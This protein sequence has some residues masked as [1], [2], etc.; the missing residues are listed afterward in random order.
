MVIF[1]YLMIYSFFYISVI[2]FVK[3]LDITILQAAYCYFN[4]TGSHSNPYSNLSEAIQSANFMLQSNLSEAVL[5][6]YFQDANYIIYDSFFPYNANLFWNWESI[7]SRNIS[8]NILPDGCL[9]NQTCNIY[10]TLDVKTLKMSFSLSSSFSLSNMIFD[11]KD[12]LLDPIKYSSM[13]CYS[14]YI[15]CCDN[16]SFYNSSNDCYLDKTV[17]RA[18]QIQMNMF[19]GSSSYNFL[20][21]SNVVFENIYSI[22]KNHYFT[23]MVKIQNNANIFIFNSSFKGLYFL[24]STIC[25]G[26]N[27]YIS[28]SNSYFIDYNPFNYY[29]EV[30]VIYFSYIFLLTESNSIIRL[31]NITVNTQFFIYSEQNTIFIDNTSL[32]IKLNSVFSLTFKENIGFIKFPYGN[33]LIITNTNFTNSPAYQLYG[34]HLMSLFATTMNS[35]INIKD[36]YFM[37]FEFDEAIFL[38][39]LVNLT[40]II[41]NSV[42]KNIG[43]RCNDLPANCINNFMTM[44]SFNTIIMNDTFFLNLTFYYDI[45][46]IYMAF[47]NR[48]SMNNCTFQTIYYNLQL[49]QNPIF[50]YMDS[51]NVL[52]FNKLIFIDYMQGTSGELFQP[53]YN[54]SLTFNDSKF[55]ANPITMTSQIVWMKNLNNISFYSTILS[56]MPSYYPGILYLESNNYIIFYNCSCSNIQSIVGGLLTIGGANSRVDFNFS[57]F[58]SIS[59]HSDGGFIYIFGSNTLIY[60]Q[61]CI[62]MSVV[63]YGQGGL[64]YV[65]VGQNIYIR[66]TIVVFSMSLSY[67][68]FIYCISQNNVFIDNLT[69]SSS[70]SLNNGGLFSG[71]QNNVYFM[72]N[73]NI[74]LTASNSGQGGCFYG[75]LSNKFYIYNVNFVNISAENE[76]GCFSLDSSNIAIMENSYSKFINT[77]TDGG[78]FF[79]KTGNYIYVSNCVFD[80]L[81]SMFSAG[82]LKAQENNNISVIN[83]NFS[84]IYSQS[85][86]GIWYLDNGNF[87]SVNGC[88]A[89]NVKALKGGIIL[90]SDKNNIGFSLN[91]FNNIQTISQGGGL[92]LYNVN[93]ISLINNTFSNISTISGV[94]GLIYAYEGNNITFIENSLFSIKSENYGGFLFF[95]IGNRINASFNVFVDCVAV[96]G[97]NIL[98]IQSNNHVYL[99][100]NT[101]IV[102]TYI[103]MIDI[104]T[105]NIICFMNNSWKIEKAEKLAYFLMAIDNNT[106]SIIYENYVFFDSFV[107]IYQIF[108]LATYNNFTIDH[109]NLTIDRCQRIFSLYDK[110]ILFLSHFTLKGFVSNYNEIFYV[111]SANLV[112]FSMKLKG[113]LIKNI[114][115]ISNST[116]FI[117]KTV[118]FTNNK[119][120]LFFICDSSNIT[121]ISSFFKGSY[122]EKNQLLQATDSYVK[123]VKS[124]AI[125]FASDGSGSVGLFTRTNFSSLKSVFSLN[126]AYSDGGVMNFSI[127]NVISNNIPKINIINS[128]FYMNKAAFHGG[129]IYVYSLSNFLEINVKKSL[130]TLNN[131]FRGGSIYIENLNNIRLVKNE[132]NQNKVNSNKFTISAYPLL[133]AKGGALYISNDYNLTNTYDFPLKI[134]V[135]YNKFTKNKADIGGVFY[136]EGIE[137]NPE[138][139]TKNKYKGNTAM[140][141][142]E[143]WASETYL[144]RFEKFD[145]SFYQ[146]DPEHDYYVKGE[147]DNIKSGYIYTDCLLKISGYDRFNALTLNTDENLMDGLFFLQMDQLSY[148]NKLSFSQ[149]KGS[150]CLNGSFLRQELPLKMTFNYEITSK[151]LQRLPVKDQNL[152]LSIDFT[153][154]SI[155]DRLTENYECVNCAKDT[156]S[157]QADFSIISEICKS[158]ENT[159]FYC[160]G[161]GNYTVKPGYWRASLNSY[162]FYLCPNQQACLGDFRNFSDET[163]EYLSIYASSYCNI[164]YKGILCAE[165]EDNYGYLDGHICTP[166]VDKNYYLQVFGN[167]LLRAIFTIYLIKVGVNMCLSILS[168]KPDRNRIIS[169]NLL[170]IFTNHMQILG[171]IFNLP[172]SFPPELLNG[173]SYF[174]S[175]SP[176]VSEAF[177]IECILKSLGSSISL[178]YFKLIMAAIYPFCLVIIFVIFVKIMNKVNL[179]LYATSHRTLKNPSITT[180]RIMENNKITHID[181]ICAVLN[182]VSLICY[183]DIAKMTMS[184]FGCVNIEE[185]SINTK[186]LLYSDFRIECDSE[187]HKQ[188]IKQTAAPIMIFFLFFYPIYL[189]LHMFMNFYKKIDNISF[190]FRFSYFFYAYKRKFFYWDFVILLR[191]LALIFINSF[192]FSRITDNVDLYPILIVIFIFSLAFG[193]QAYCKPFATESFYM[194]NGVEEYSLVVSFYTVIIALIYMITGN[195]NKSLVTGL[196][197]LGFLLNLSFFVLWMIFYLKYHNSFRRFTRIFVSKYYLY[198]IYIFS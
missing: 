192:F 29:E 115:T 105:D 183:A 50:V 20:W 56:H 191:K 68:G 3:A 118:Y 160:Y 172:I 70:S 78:F 93:N 184:M 104:E 48:I 40:I 129:C 125:N 107:D 171:F 177:S 99:Y 150:I 51:N 178:Q 127:E 10:T 175:V 74:M 97:G 103:E 188:W 90:V 96:L 30:P 158:C 168:E 130:F 157:F 124:T 86:G 108:Y 9:F 88:F 72:N 102:N 187:Y 110:S 174:L 166:C 109:C 5:N 152:I 1:P 75:F 44:S 117:N 144:L 7:L 195:S 23:N 100:N 49:S 163:T 154:C 13:N 8:I 134:H 186:K 193:L 169:S 60:M 151:L 52:T 120:S 37:N 101:F 59:A 87:L 132:F 196:L 26:R 36:S 24:N 147:I 45:S 12:S 155:G 79:A 180:P 148:Y 112:I 185:N 128:I 198:N 156:Y 153:S 66:D 113:N 197:V 41:K 149:N 32:L 22:D 2:H 33:S 137:I 141:Y 162:T 123:F 77:N 43:K 165:C 145:R 92:W 182:L 76:G 31:S 6:I 135:N 143:I 85:D 57:S 38:N 14:S 82:F 63:S 46:F 71:I 16:A 142:G 4:C 83:S 167:I 54:N 122:Q 140:Y 28:I 53:L 106:G 81:N 25:S 116:V 131:A 121:I 119:N 65:Q 17:I 170:K 42:F 126:L 84:R 27:S 138:N 18:S 133:R 176:N 39:G 11:Y 146:F 173:F 21:M 161:G 181:L 190:N 19:E 69:I 164:G 91:S 73:S 98:Y 62:F 95:S 55:E 94:G 89:E 35:T 194:I 61:S 159:N 111:K 179:I 114:L 47:N 80:E 67:G 139:F 58:T 189:I 34:P 136:V 64:F 15:G